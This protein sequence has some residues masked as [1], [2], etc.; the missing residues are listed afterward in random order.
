MPPNG[1][2]GWR[3]PLGWVAV[4]VGGAARPPEAARWQLEGWEAAR[5]PP[6]SL[7]P[8]R[9]RPPP[10]WRRHHRVRVHRAAYRGRGAAEHAGHDVTA[11]ALALQIQ[12]DT[13]RGPDHAKKMAKKGLLMAFHPDK[14][15]QAAARQ[16][17]LGT[18]V[19]QILNAKVK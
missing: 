10:G 17:W 1:S 19:T 2:W 3:R 12:V 8:G 9:D 18:C 16:Q 11:F 5:P 13:S 6:S 7:R 15:G 4:R 14:L